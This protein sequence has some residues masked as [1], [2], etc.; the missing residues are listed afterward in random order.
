MV[1]VVVAPHVDMQNLSTSASL[2]HHLFTSESWQ[3][4]YIVSAVFPLL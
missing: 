3:L 2:S 4:F 1:A